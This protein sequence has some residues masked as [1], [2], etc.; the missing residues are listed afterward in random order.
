MLTCPTCAST[1]LIVQSESRR[2]EHYPIYGV[3]IDTRVRSVTDRHIVDQVY[4]EQCHSWFMVDIKPIQGTY[5]ANVQ[6]MTNAEDARFVIP[7]GSTLNEIADHHGWN[8][9]DLAT[10]LKMSPADTAKLLSGRYRIDDKL[11]HVLEAATGP[12]AGFWLNLERS[13]RRDM[14]LYADDIEEETEDD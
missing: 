2:V 10:R 11:A 6:I 3:R 14:G 13:F 8:L 7:P 12:P 1:M 9:E 5:F 4:C